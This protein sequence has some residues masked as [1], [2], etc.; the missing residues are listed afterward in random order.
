M[1]AKVVSGACDGGV[2]WAVTFVLFEDGKEPHPQLLLE[3]W[4]TLDFES[5]NTA[6]CWGSSIVGD[7]F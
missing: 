2:N 7:Q 4:T 3:R 6:L 1:V 5:L